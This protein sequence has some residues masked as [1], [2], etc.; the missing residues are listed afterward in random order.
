MLVRATSAG[1]L[2]SSSASS[3][4]RP[5]PLFLRGQGGPRHDG[6]RGNAV[7]LRQGG[8]ALKQAG[9]CRATALHQLQIDL[10]LTQVLKLVVQPARVKT[11][12]ASRAAKLLGQREL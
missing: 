2:E 8:I 4:L 7:Q 6:V 11:D 5:P 9:H 3:A 12:V 10:R 1:T